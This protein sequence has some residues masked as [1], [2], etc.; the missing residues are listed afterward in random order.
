MDLKSVKY[1]VDGGNFN[2]K[3]NNMKNIH[4]LPTDKSSRLYYFT[5]NKPGFYLYPKNQLLT[6]VNPNYINQNFYITSDEEIKEGDYYITPN[7]TVLKALGPML[8]NVEDYKKIILT[9]DFR[10]A[11]DVQKIDNEFLEWFVQNP[12]C[13]FVEV[14]YEPK[15][16]LDTK[17][18]WEYEII[19]P[20]KNFYCGDKFDYDEQCEFQCDTCVDKKGV[21]YGYLPKEEPKKVLTEED[22]FNQKDIDAVTDYINKEQ[23]KQ[24]LI[25]M[26]KSDEELGLY[27]EVYSK[28]GIALT[29]DYIQNIEKEIKLEEV[30]NDEKK[31]NLKKF[32]DEIKNPSEPNQALKDAAHRYEKY[33]ERFDND[34]SAIGNPQTW[35]KRLICKDCNESLEDCTCIQD[36]VEFL[37][38]GTTIE[39]VAEKLKGR[40]LFKESNDRARKTL[41]EI[42]SLPIQETLEDKLKELVLEWQKRQEK[43]YDIAYENVDNVH[44]N[45]KFTYKAMATRD[46]WKELLKL[47]ENEK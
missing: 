40:E 11:P 15:N 37:K 45:R 42:K 8:I 26:M 13:E 43:Y 21:D 41:S 2:L 7:N 16:F 31:E 20:K 30:F 17:Q 25:D 3:T 28:Q 32:I 47:I 6:P 36:T 24:H 38:Q 29:S 39:E 14:I 27:G 23:Q 9:T 5:G 22:I 34:K 35:G 46:C 33:S 10:L 12:S 1:V 19:I 44:T 18:G 4:I